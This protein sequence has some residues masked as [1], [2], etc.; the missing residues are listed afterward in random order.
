MKDIISQNLDDPEALEALYRENKNGFANEFHEATEGQDSELIRFWRLR[1]RN[2]FPLSRMNFLKADLWLLAGISLVIA[3]LVK[4]HLLFAV[5]E[6]DYWLRNLPLIIFS[7]LTAW[8]VVKKKLNGAARIVALALPVILLA[9]VMNLLP[10]AYSDTNNLAFIHVPFFMWFIFGLAW[11]SLDYRK[12]TTVASFIRYNGELLIMFGLLVIAGAILSAMTVSLFSVIGMDIGEF[13]M[14]NI[15]IV[16]LAVFPVLAALLIDLYPDITSRISPIIAR[17]FTPIVLVSAVIYL[18]AML[19]SGADL[20]A[21]RDLLIIFNL[22]LLGVMAI[23]V[24][25]LSELDH[26]NIRKFNVVLL[27]LLAAVTLA[28][29]LFALSGILSRLAEGF[30]PNRTAVLV[31]NLLVLVHLLMVLPGLF[32]AGF[33][34]RSLKPVE[35]IVYGYI[36]VYFVYVASVIFLFPLIF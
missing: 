35:K 26:S 33:L 13:Y 32:Q 3:L 11:T 23:I 19:A 15:G 30:T 34:G 18:V 12:T 31:S 2:D 6:E 8:F 22:L 7:G 5:N 20:S 17:I 25:S 10:A 28:I 1:L 29:D 14:Q 36:P 4:A 24:F 27:F 21:D 9:I 16:G